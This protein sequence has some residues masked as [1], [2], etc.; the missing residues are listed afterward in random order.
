MDRRIRLHDMQELQSNSNRKL[1]LIYSHT[2]MIN[3]KLV[4][5]FLRA[6]HYDDVTQ[7]QQ[8]F[9]H[10]LSYIN[11]KSEFCNLQSSSTLIKWL[12]SGDR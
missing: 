1:Q 8:I 4:C 9:S 3:E 2:L 5:V 6:L 12:C 11:M 10:S 7:E